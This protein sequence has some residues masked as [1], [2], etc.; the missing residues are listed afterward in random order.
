MVYI[1]TMKHIVPLLILSLLALTSCN[2]ER[3][4]LKP[5]T[6][7]SSIDLTR[8]EGR[9]YEI[10]RFDMWF[11]KNCVGVTADYKILATDKISVVNSC[12]LH[13]LDG[14][15]KTATGTARVPDPAYPAQLKVRFDQFG[16]NL[17]EGDYWV[18]ALDKHYKWAVV[19]SEAGKSLW[20]LSRTPRMNDKT[21]NKIIADLKTKGIRTEFLI[22]TEQPE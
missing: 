22:K 8:Y 14:E 4:A 17:F 6:S 10:A 20:I 21:Y 5:Q 11:Q 15:L 3:A 12:R 18:I 7:V 13:T 19:S 16:A 9:W 1:Y 2:S